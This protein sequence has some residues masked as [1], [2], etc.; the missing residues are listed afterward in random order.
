MGYTGWSYQVHTWKLHKDDRPTCGAQNGCHGNAGCLATGP[1]NPIYDLIFQNENVYKLPNRHIHSS[2][3]PGHVTQFLGKF[4]RSRSQWHIMYI[5]KMCL[6]SIPGG[7]INF[8]L[9]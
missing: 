2:T 5:G 7:P 6:N 8:I 3:R 9:G 4:T 1:L